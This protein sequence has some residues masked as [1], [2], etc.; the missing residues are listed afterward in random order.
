MRI[1]SKNKSHGPGDSSDNGVLMAG[2]TKAV[3]STAS[4]IAFKDVAASFARSLLRLAASR[5]SWSG[6]KS[7]PV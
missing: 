2:M 7:A 3:P 6:V 1:A 5:R 4:A